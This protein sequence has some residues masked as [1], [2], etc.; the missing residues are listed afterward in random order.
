[1]PLKTGD[2]HWL[3]GP[4]WSHLIYYLQNKSFIQINLNCFLS[5]VPL[6]VLAS[7]ILALYDQVVCEYAF[8]TNFSSNFIPLYY[9]EIFMTS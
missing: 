6:E 4:P 1:M 7:L 5:L 2:K 3:Y 8:Y 9:P